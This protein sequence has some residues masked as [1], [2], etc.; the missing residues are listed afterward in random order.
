MRQAKALDKR[1]GEN[2]RGV[3]RLAQIAANDKDYVT[4]IDGFE[5]ILTTQ[6]P[7]SPYFLEAKRASLQTKRRQ[8][9]D[10]Y[11]YTT[12]QLKGL[13]AEYQACLDAYG[14][15]AGTAQIVSEYAMLEALYVN[16]LPKA[17]ELLEQVVNLPGINNYVQAYA[18]LD[19]GDYYLMSGEVWESTLLYSQVDKAFV[20]DLIGQGCRDLRNARLSYYNGDFEWAQAQF[21][22]LKTSTSKLISNDALDMSIFIMDNLG[23][24][25]NTHALSEYAQAELLIFQNKL[26]EAI[27][28]LNILGNIYSEHGLKDDILYL[29]ARLYEKKRDYL[30]AETLYQEIIEKFPDE[31]P[32]AQCPLQPGPTI[33]ASTQ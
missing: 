27:E 1:M 19:L 26:D 30:K 31:T 29:E 13:E 21:D 9:T 14:I 5:Y 6:S 11:S 22:I 33:R 10:N 8:I 16:D 25:S 24:D 7:G 17:I 2:G 12:E 4:A 32:C 3:Y 15:H 18:K 28:K 20:E 23:L